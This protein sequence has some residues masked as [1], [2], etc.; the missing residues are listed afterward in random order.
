MSSII[1]LLVVLVIVI[2][3]VI[4]RFYFSR[5]VGLLAKELLVLLRDSKQPMNVSQLEAASGS[6]GGYVTLAVDFLVRHGY[7]TVP[8]RRPANSR[9]QR[10][11]SAIASRTRAGGT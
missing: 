11:A 5:K 1:V 8:T 10:T 2:M 3:I 4:T 6:H 9:L 7:A